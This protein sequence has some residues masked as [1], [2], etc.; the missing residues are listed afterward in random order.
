MFKWEVNFKKKNML[1]TSSMDQGYSNA[2]SIQVLIGILGDWRAV[3]HLG[4]FV[5]F[6]E[7]FLGSFYGGGGC[8][9]CIW[10]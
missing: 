4:L 10:I 5:V 8:S 6:L 2:L 7:P 9:V 3:K 1:K